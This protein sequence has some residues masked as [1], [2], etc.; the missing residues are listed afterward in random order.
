MLL[1]GS[2]TRAFRDRLSGATS[3]SLA[4]IDPDC[5]VAV[6]RAAMPRS[7]RLRRAV[8]ELLQETVPQ[9]EREVRLD[10][11]QR[12]QSNS[13][14]D[15]DF[16]ALTWL[17]TVIA[18]VGLLQ[19]SAAVIIGAMLVAP[20]MTP[21]LGM[22]LAM[23]QGNPR[24]VRAATSSVVAGMATAFLL[25]LVLGLI[26]PGFYVPTP[27]ML[28][29]N[30][31]G[32]L[33][34]FVAFVSGLAAAYSSSRPNLLAALPG[35]AIAA[36]LVP[37]IATSGLALALSDYDLVGGAMLL[38]LT[39]RVA[40]VLAA[41]VVIW[42]VGVRGAAGG[43]RATR[44]AGWSTSPASIAIAVFLG[45]ARPRYRAPDAVPQPLCPRTSGCWS[46]TW[47]AA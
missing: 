30:W 45:L 39:N 44:V 2:A 38:F 21:M 15:F 41:A 8:E 28:K 9:M 37:P 36:S 6:V 31:P 26:V 7:G 42:C 43:T 20:L 3:Q 33:D 34:L 14:W 25:A 47:I 27:E 11:V 35:V 18:S 17:A 4:N 13:L 29:R 5:C 19:D 46:W 23:V 24:L 16:R 40:I 22:G 10:L 32:M 1:G 12:V